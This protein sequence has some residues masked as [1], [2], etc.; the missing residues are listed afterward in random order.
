MPY[1][2][3]QSSVPKEQLISSFHGL[4]TSISKE[5]VPEQVVCFN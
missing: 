2:T 4:V 5:A 3:L 1:G